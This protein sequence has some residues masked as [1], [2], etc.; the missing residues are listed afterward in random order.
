MPSSTTSRLPGLSPSRRRRASRLDGS[1]CL[2]RID[3]GLGQLAGVV[4][5]G[6]AV[7]VDQQ[8]VALAD[9]GRDHAEIGLVAG[10]EDHAVLLAVELGDLLLERHVLGV[11]AVGDARAGGAGA[12]A[13]DRLD[14]GLHAGRIEGQA[15]I[16]VGADQQVL[17]PLMIASVGDST[18]SMRIW[19]GS[20]P[21]GADV[22][23]GARAARRG[24]RTGPWRSNAG[25]RAS[26]WCRRAR[27]RCGS[28]PRR[29]SG[30]RRRTGPRAP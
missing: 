27:R 17:R 8:V 19:N 24:D 16:V 5:R 20:S 1:L 29:S 21:V 7:G 18:R 9:Q 2:K 12:L 15:E 4:D 30:S 11:A 10:R 23:I 14:G 3:L 26:E 22:A 28:R 25:R 6:V 13:A